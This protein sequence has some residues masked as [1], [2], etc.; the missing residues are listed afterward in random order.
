MVRSAPHVRNITPHFDEECTRTI[1]E[2]FVLVSTSQNST[3]QSPPSFSSLYRN[4]A[5]DL[6]G[7]H[8]RAPSLLGRRVVVIGL[9][10]G[11]VA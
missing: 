10:Y 8:R 11:V 3:E 4:F 2:R 1:I 7:R 5:L 6:V 9:C